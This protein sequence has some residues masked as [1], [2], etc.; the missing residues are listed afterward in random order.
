[1]KSRLVF[2]AVLLFVSA[3]LHAA[4]PAG[5]QVVHKDGRFELLRNGEPCLVKGGGGGEHALE[6]LS[7]DWQRY[8][9]D[10][11]T[12]DFTRIQTGFV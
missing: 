10:V 1:M 12:Q 2:P 8:E 4:T 5:V 11:S 3:T 7:K 6:S 9:I